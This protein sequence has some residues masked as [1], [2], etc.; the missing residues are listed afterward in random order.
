MSTSTGIP[1]ILGL[2][3]RVR[4]ASIVVGAVVLAAAAVACG[5]PTAPATVKSVVVTGSAPAVGSSSQFTATATMSNGTTLD[6]TSSSTW[7]SSDSTVATVSTTG[8]VTGVAEGSASIQAT[9]L[10]VSGTD[11]VVVP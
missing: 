1:A 2:S 9:Y 11:V 7:S 3:A 6:V 5:S 4:R 8:T 10:S